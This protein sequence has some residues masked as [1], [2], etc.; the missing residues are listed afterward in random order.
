MDGVL[1][2][3]R[4]GHHTN[5]VKVKRKVKVTLTIEQATKA[6]WGSKGIALL[7]L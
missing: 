5:K 1:T 6:Q 2:E 3:F 7:F 4:V